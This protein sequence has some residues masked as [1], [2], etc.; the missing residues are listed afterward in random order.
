[1]TTRERIITALRGGKPDRIPLTVYEMLYPRGQNERLA[2]EAGVGLVL[3]PPAHAVEHRQVEIVSM[4]YWEQGRKRIR[5]TIRTPVGEVWQTLEPDTTGYEDNTWIREHFIKGP[6]DYRVMEYFVRDGVYHDTYTHLRELRRRI[7]EDGLVYVRLAKSPVQEMLYQMMGRERFSF[8]YY[9]RRDLFDSLHETMVG[10][11]RELYDL[12]A[13]A[14]VELILLGDNIS[15]EV[16]GT[17]RFLTYL[18]PVYR[19]LH[20]RLSGTGKLLAVHA[21]GRTGSLRAE[22]AA[23]DIDVVEAFTP[24]PMNDMTVKDAR[25]A[26]KGKSLWINFTSSLHIARPEEIERHT[27]Q[28]VEEAGDRRGFA[29]GVTENAPVEALEHSLLIIARVLSEA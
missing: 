17:D 24:A 19:E 10:R 11:F 3:R 9:D 13:G 12:A 26:W 8:D 4:E 1:M 22:I 7:G 23:A 27:R 20:A 5:R 2:R 28:I 14:P 6:D 15:S 16:V 21:D 18:A 25:D 29:I